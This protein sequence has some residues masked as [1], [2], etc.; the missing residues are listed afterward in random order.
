MWASQ[1]L[2]RLTTESI[3]E[4]VCYYKTCNEVEFYGKREE[5]GPLYS[6]MFKAVGRD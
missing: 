1:Q 5:E 4:T 3:T 2:F 6:H